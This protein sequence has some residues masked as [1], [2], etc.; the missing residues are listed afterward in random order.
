L[1]L[2]AWATWLAASADAQ[3]RPA[4]VR[5]GEVVERDTARGRSFVGTVY[6]KRSS[7]VGST[8]RGRV[9]EFLVDEGDEVDADQPLVKLRTRDLEIDLAGAEAELD[10]RR[11]ELAELENGTRPEEIEQARARMLAAAALKDYTA[12]RLRRTEKL[13]AR[14]ATS[15]DD[16]QEVRSAAQA[17]AQRHIEAEQAYKLAVAGPRREDIAQAR[18]RMLVAQEQVNRLKDDIAQHTVR[19]PFHG[20]VTDEFTEVGQWVAEG[21]PV[22]E[23]VD[24]DRVEIE[25]PVLEKYAAKIR[26]G[27]PARVTVDARPGEQWTAEVSAVVPKAERRSRS[28]PVKIE[29]DNPPRAGGL[30]FQPGMFAR[31]TLSVGSD[32][33]VLLVPKDAVVL[34]G[35]SPLVFVVAKP[36]ATPGGAGG[37]SGSGDGAATSGGKID[38]VARATPV[39]L[40]ASVDELI[41]VRGELKPGDW[42]VEVGNE[43]VRPGQPLV[44]IGTSE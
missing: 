14:N 40:G 16:M 42:V 35:R 6:A 13:Y 10:L 29:L 41:E 18:A 39:E 11:Q 36:A 37:E 30:T 26:V 21:A 20:Y 15:E 4:R 27:M 28:F 7:T 23:M 2:T 44:V 43:R 33:P 22:V 17:A 25:I 3:M 1:I 31:V 34:G 32:V 8:V 12:A 9:I 24:I 19:A 5:V 38:G